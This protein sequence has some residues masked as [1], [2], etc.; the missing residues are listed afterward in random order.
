MAPQTNASFAK[1][2]KVFAK[3]K[4]YPYWPA[5]ITNI[6]SKEHAKLKK[7]NVTFFGTNDTAIIKQTDLCSYLENKT[8][9]GQPKTQNLKNEKFNKALKDAEASFRS[10][11]LTKNKNLSVKT[12]HSN[13]QPNKPTLSPVT[14]NSTLLSI[15]RN[16]SCNET[17]LFAESVVSIGMNGSIQTSNYECTDI[18]TAASSPLI[19]HCNQQ[20]SNAFVGEQSL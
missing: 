16:T 10:S 12:I 14:D 15:R 13:I 9:Y 11:P 7:F 6:E 20:T 1:G 17:S 2:D 4:G 19:V 18:P 8:K 3:L 5:L